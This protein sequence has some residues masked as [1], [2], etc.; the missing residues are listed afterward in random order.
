MIIRRM[1]ILFIFILLRKR[2]N[3]FI[4]F[5]SI[6]RIT[7]DTFEISDEFMKI[8]NCDPEYTKKLYEEIF[9]FTQ[10][11]KDKKDPHSSNTH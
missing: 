8:I 10:K 5:F 7:I 2:K 1:R 6:L 11:N 9:T 4:E 3:F